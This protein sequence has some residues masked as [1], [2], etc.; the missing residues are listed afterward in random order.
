MPVDVAEAEALWPH[1][2]GRRLEKVR[3]RV[4]VAGGVAEVD[5][6]GGELTG[7]WTVEVEFDVGAGGRRLPPP[8]WFGAEVTD[9]DGWSNAALARHGR[10]GPANSE[11]IAA[12]RPAAYRSAVGVGRLRAMPSGAEWFIVLA[13]VLVIF[14][15]SQLP[16]LARNLGKA[17]KEF[18]DGLAEGQADDGGRAG[19]RSGRRPRSRDRTDVADDA[20]AGRD[21]R[22]RLDVVSR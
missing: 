18:K 7:L 21:R 19:G 17:Q 9:V 13:V 5:R 4:P 10:P 14:G 12:N 20:R 3:H 15:G 2:V 11:Q 22:R 8:P 6:Y 16:K 1:T